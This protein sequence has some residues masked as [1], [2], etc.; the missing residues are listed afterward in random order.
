MRT[1]Y[2]HRQGKGKISEKYDN[3]EEAIGQVPANT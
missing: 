2:F 1:L 3:H